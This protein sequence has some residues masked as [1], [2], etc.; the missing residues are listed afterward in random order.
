MM[1]KYVGKIFFE[2]PNNSCQNC[3]QS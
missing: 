2:I 3:K 1:A